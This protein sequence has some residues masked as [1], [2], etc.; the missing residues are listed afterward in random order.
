MT[1]TTSTAAVPIRHVAG[2]KLEPKLS[3]SELIT[4][5][6]QNQVPMAMAVATATATITTATATSSL[7]KPSSVKKLSIGNV[8]H[9]DPGS[10][11]VSATT[12]NKS[13]TEKEKTVFKP[14]A[15][16]IQVFQK[17]QLPTQQHPAPFNSTTS[18]TLTSAPP[19][20][21]PPPLPLPL[22][23]ARN[24][25]SAATRSRPHQFSWDVRALPRLPEDTGSPPAEEPSRSAPSFT[26]VVS[27]DEKKTKKLQPKALEDQNNKGIGKSTS[28]R[29]P[30]EVEVDFGLRSGSVSSDTGCSSS[31]DLSDRSSDAEGADRSNSSA[32]GATS[33]TA[34][35]VGGGGGNSHR[36]AMSEDGATP[37]PATANW[38]GRPRSFSVQAD[39]SFLAQP[40]NRVCTGS[41]ARAFEKFGTKVESESAAGSATTT[42]AAASATAASASSISSASGHS[43]F[44]NRSRRQSTP[45]PFK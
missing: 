18:S 13:F 42:A 25:E 39:I 32:V 17:S 29:T 7:I 30:L 35:S 15:A 10:A 45:G 34:S 33:K 44:A 38:T 24:S 11:S 14:V 3:V 27:K 20:P 8:F 21:P 36:E 1:T 23:S 40:W 19:P 4:S 5:F 28:T 6:N 41:V 26:S 22:L 16:S 37:E 2:K 31:S 43:K 12:A 9:H